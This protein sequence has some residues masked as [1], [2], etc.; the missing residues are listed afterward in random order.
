M[1][2]R[3]ESTLLTLFQRGRTGD[4]RRGS[5]GDHCLPEARGGRGTSRGETVETFETHIS[6]VFLAGRR[7]LKLKR[8]VRL[9]YV[10]LSTAERRLAIAE[11]EVG[12]NRRTAPKLY[13]GVRRVTRENDGRLALDGKRRPR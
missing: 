8:A 13:V 2:G 12:L 1:G 10:D 4:D 5:V 7:A 9:P 3:V 6:I 11:R